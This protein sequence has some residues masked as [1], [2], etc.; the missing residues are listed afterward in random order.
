MATAVVQD[1]GHHNLLGTVAAH[2]SPAEYASTPML[3]QVLKAFKQNVEPRAEQ[4]FEA[5]G[6]LWAEHDMFNQFALALVHRHFEMADDE[7]LVE[8]EE[9]G[10]AWISQ[11]RVVASDADQAQI[12]AHYWKVSADG[13][14]APIEFS[15]ESATASTPKMDSGAVLRFVAAF[16][17]L[18]AELGVQ[19][20]F[21]LSAQDGRPIDTAATYE[22]TN[23]R[24][25][26]V[27]VSLGIRGG[28]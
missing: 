1:F 16:V 13:Q 23:G 5:F 6:R 28:I 15:A 20:I 21:G 9:G 19:G 25:N 2:Y 11:P 17:Q 8:T 7:R 18:C 27:C 26:E 4:V 12:C 10:Q 14:L 22:I 24:V 3:S